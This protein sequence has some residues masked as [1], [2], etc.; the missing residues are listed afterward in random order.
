MVFFKHICKHVKVGDGGHSHK[1]PLLKFRM[2]HLKDRKLT[3]YV[4]GKGE[5]MKVETI[6]ERDKGFM[7]LI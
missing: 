6:K 1:G 4:K 5:I 3:F 2:W 7:C